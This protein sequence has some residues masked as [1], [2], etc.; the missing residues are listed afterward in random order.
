MNPAQDM[1]CLFIICTGQ[2]IELTSNSATVMMG[3]LKLAW[4]M[5]TCW[6][7]SFCNS[8][9]FLKSKETDCVSTLH[10]NR[11]NIPSLMKVKKWRGENSSAIFQGHGTITEE[12]WWSPHITQ[13]RRKNITRLVLLFDCSTHKGQSKRSNAAAVLLEW[14]KCSTWCVKLLKGLLSVAIFS[15]SVVIY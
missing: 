4:Y 3:F 10:V 12:W 9:D 13:M 7:D 11:N 14:K 2:G 8:P 1:S 6:M 5:V 15:N